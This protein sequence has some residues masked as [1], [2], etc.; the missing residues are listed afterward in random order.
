MVPVIINKNLVYKKYQHYQRSSYQLP[1]DFIKDKLNIISFPSDL[2]FTE[3]KKNEI[4]LKLQQLDIR[5]DFD[6]ILNFNI[7]MKLAA[8][9]K[10]FT[11]G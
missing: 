5:I 9:D 10:L 1:N 8:F 6:R 11:G 3:E 2:E 4:I 7:D